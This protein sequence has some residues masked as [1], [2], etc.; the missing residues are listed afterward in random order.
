MKAI[1]VKFT[2]GSYNI[3]EDLK[4]EGFSWDKDNKCWVKTYEDKKDFDEF[5]SKYTNPTWNGRKGARIF[6]NVSYEIEEVKEMKEQ[7]DRVEDTKPETKEQVEEGIKEA[8]TKYIAQGDINEFAEV[9]D[10]RQAFIDGAEWWINSVWHNRDE[11][12]NGV[13]LLLIEENDG[14]YEL[15]YVIHKN[16]KRWL[17]VKDIVKG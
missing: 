10:V 1:I 8:S 6:S 9:S 15:D 12:P 3:K 14:E 13:S 7:E 4:K 2:D 16:T 17:Y 11:T 5:Y